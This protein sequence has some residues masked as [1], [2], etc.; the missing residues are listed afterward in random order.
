MR[1]SFGAVRQKAEDLR[2]RGKAQRGD[3][4]VEHDLLRRTR[5]S[6]RF[7]TL[8]HCTMD[9]DNPA[10]AKCL[11]DAIVPEGHRGPLLDRCQ[12]GRCANSVIGPQHVPIWKAER[13]SLTRL[14]A[15]PKLPKNRRA[16]LSAQ[17]H[18]VDLVIKRAEP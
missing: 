6:I 9:D 5:I 15:T 18:D 11:E 13:A 14:I 2:A 10:G 1:E 4:R 8:N 16:A 17:L 3:V 12:P 7:G